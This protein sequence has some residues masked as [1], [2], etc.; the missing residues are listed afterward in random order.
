MAYSPYAKP[1]TAKIVVIT[2]NDIADI[3]A[4]FAAKAETLPKFIQLNKWTRI[5][6]VQLCISTDLER[7]K[8]KDCKAIYTS[9]YDHLKELKQYCITNKL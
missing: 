8:Q 1:H 9:A 6:N 3:Q 7:L 4:F 5:T 2:D